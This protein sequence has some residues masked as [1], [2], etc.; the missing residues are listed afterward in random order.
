MIDNIK[1]AVKLDGFHL[2]IHGFER[3]I[4]R[5]ISPDEIREALLSGEIIEDYLQDKYGPSC[6]V[7]GITKSGRLLHINCSISP[8]WIITAYDPT[9]NPDDWD[10]EFRER[11]SRP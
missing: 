9:L 8:V 4:E 11:R 6:L 1:N 5:D 2:T 3:C 10:K 7:M